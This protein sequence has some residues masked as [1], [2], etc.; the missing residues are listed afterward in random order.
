[1]PDI[2]SEAEAISTNLSFQKDEPSV[3]SGSICPSV[4]VDVDPCNVQM[5]NSLSNTDWPSVSNLVRRHS[6]SLLNRSPNSGSLAEE[7]LGTKFER[8]NTQTILLRNSIKDLT[9][10]VSNYNSCQSTADSSSDEDTGKALEAVKKKGKKR[11]L[12]ASPNLREQQK[13]VNTRKSP[14]QNN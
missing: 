4:S 13:K 10:T 11:S 6:L 5:K 14:K 1:M 12:Q 2:V 8:L 9:D 7:L 3:N